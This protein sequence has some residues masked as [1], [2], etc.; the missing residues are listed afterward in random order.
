MRTSKKARRTAT[1]AQI[2]HVWRPAHR[3]YSSRR[4]RIQLARPDRRLFMAQPSSKALN[5]SDLPARANEDRDDQDENDE[6][7]D[8]QAQVRCLELR[9]GP[10]D[11][12]WSAGVDRR[13]AAVA[14]AGWLRYR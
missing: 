11:R 12:G 10:S 6:S 2:N 5:R 1:M 4:S 7:E 9:A 3:L 8:H 13:P 14:E